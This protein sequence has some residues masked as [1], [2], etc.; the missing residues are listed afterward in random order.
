MTSSDSSTTT[1]H[2]EV[3]IT[4]EGPLISTTTA[5]FSST[6]TQ[7]TASTK[8]PLECEN[9]GTPTNNNCLCPPGFTGRIC[10]T[11]AAEIKAPD[12]IERSAIA[13][14]EVNKQYLPEY[15]NTSSAEYQDFVTVFRNQM[16][17]FYKTNIKNFVDITNI[18]L[19]KGEP[20]S[21]RRHRRWTERT[22]LTVTSVNVKHDIV[23]EVQ[24][25]IVAYD[26][27]LVQVYETLSALQNCSSDCHLNFTITNAEVTRTELNGT[28]LCENTTAVLPEE[29][30]Q[31]YSNVTISGKLTCVTQCHQN[32][33]NPKLCENRG[34]CEVSRHGPACYCLHTDANWYLGEDCKFQV[35]KVGLYSGIGVV[36]VVLVIAVA[37]LSAYVFINRRRTRRDKDNKDDLVNQWL[38]DDFEWPSPSRSSTSHSAAS[39]AYDNVAYADE[40]FYR[41]QSNRTQRSLSSTQPSFSPQQQIPSGYLHNNHPVRISRPQI[42]G[43]LHV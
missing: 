15:D 2:L 11:V 34:T 9:G 13:E 6:T 36:S 5:V 22:S 29:Y 10:N 1:D 24:N 35:N 42:R 27:V 14:V 32:H 39:L 28:E 38:D 25:D 41:Q 12:V 17:P 4:P 3:T 20:I 23:V 7:T 37:V 19:S 40:N 16:T 43:S 26:E 8:S 18:I 33:P 31:Y 30:R 21:Q